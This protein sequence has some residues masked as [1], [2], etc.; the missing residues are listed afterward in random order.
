MRS[1]AVAGFVALALLGACG[2]SSTRNSSE[3]PTTVL[4]NPQTPASST[5]ESISTTT[6]ATTSTIPYAVTWDDIVT[7]DESLL[8]TDWCKHLDKTSNQRGDLRRYGWTYTPGFPRA[9]HLP[10]TKQDLRVLIIPMTTTDSVFDQYDQNMIEDG[11]KLANEYYR[12]MSYGAVGIE[13]DI[14]PQEFWVNLEGSLQSEG[15]FRPTDQSLPGADG[16]PHAD[17]SDK[18]VDILE[19][20]SQNITI[21]GYDVVGVTSAWHPEFYAGHVYGPP[22]GI[23]TASG[24]IYSTFF[25]GGRA[26]MN[27]TAWVHEFGHAWLGFEDLY[28]LKDFNIVYLGRWDM[29]EWAGGFAEF[30]AWMRWRSDWITDQQIRCLTPDADSLHYVEAVHLASDNPKGLVIRLDEYRVLFVESHRTNPNNPT[31]DHAIVYEIDTNYWS[32]QGPFRL[33]GVLDS[34]GVEIKAYDFTFTLEDL[35]GN[36]DLIRVSVNNK[37]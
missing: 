12:E 34:I 14:A 5:T 21:A 30:N 4:S 16:V 1:S 17:L 32:G 26:I 22:E 8:P 27:P 7:P 15:F 13:Y 20:A 31:L 19:I 33:V 11:M 23:E 2:E 25:K 18:I 9:A 24:T 36:G 28:D 6:L 3:V 37:P 35:D 29:M 10:A